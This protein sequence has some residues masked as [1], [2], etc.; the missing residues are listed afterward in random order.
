MAAETLPNQDALSTMKESLDDLELAIGEAMDAPAEWTFEND[1]Y[2]QR[3]LSFSEDLVDMRLMESSQESSSVDDR[4]GMVFGNYR[5]DEFLAQGG[6]GAVYRATHTSLDRVV[7][8]KMLTSARMHHPRSITRFQRE[9]KAVGRLDHPNIVKAHDAGESDGVSYLAMELVD[10]IDLSTLLKQSGTLAVADACEIIRQ[11]AEGLQ[12]IHDQGLIHRDIK[13]SNIMLTCEGE[14]KIMD[15]GLAHVG[16]L[17]EEDELTR[18][19]QV[20]GTLDYMAPEQALDATSIDHRADIY[21]LGVTFYKLLAGVTPYCHEKYSNPLQKTRA[22]LSVSPSPIT[23]HRVGLPQELVDCIRQALERNLEDRI[24]SSSMLS[25]A[26]APFVA[27]ADLKSIVSYSATSV[28]IVSQPLAEESVKTTGIS[29]SHILLG[30]ILSTVIAF[31]VWFGIFQDFTHPSSGANNESVLISNS[32][33]PESASATWDPLTPFGFRQ[34]WDPKSILRNYKVS[35][36]QAGIPRSMADNFILPLDYDPQNN[37][38]KL[39][40]WGA[41]NKNHLVDSSMFQITILDDNDGFPS[42]DIGTRDVHSDHIAKGEKQPIQADSD[43]IRTM[44]YQLEIPWE[45]PLQAHQT[46]WLVI[47]DNDSRTKGNLSEER[48][49]D[50]NLWQWAPSA[51]LGGAMVQWTGEETWSNP[52]LSLCDRAFQIEIVDKPSHEMSPSK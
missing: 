49:S 48:S 39:T 32:H 41:M 9:M 15:L 34:K 46:Y 13:P 24:E 35:D 10:G 51:S 27:G 25:G 31:L 14:I 33:R 42:E 29:Y 12:Y 22:M 28:Q 43:R 26:L 7:A 17:G 40:W 20:M 47:T 5:I 38:L 11:I 2:F 37:R 21:S 16:G 8:L 3:A 52:R 36:L 23:Q 50:I 1:A 4:I 45:R 19:G 18:T 6:M 30:A 44:K